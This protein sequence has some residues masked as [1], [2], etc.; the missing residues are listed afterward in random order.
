MTQGCLCSLATVQ[1]TAT[2]NEGLSW[3]PLFPVLQEHQKMWVWVKLG[4]NLWYPLVNVCKKLWTD[5]PFL[6]GKLTISMAIFNS[7][8][9]VITRAYPWTHLR[10]I[11]SSQPAVVL[12]VSPKC[13]RGGWHISS[14]PSVKRQAVFLTWSHGKSTSLSARTVSKQKAS[15]NNLPKAEM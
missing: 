6:M 12:Q 11:F 14:M 1:K 7:R 8:L 13:C 15:L 2:D 10:L 9:L 3:P 5:P 4:S